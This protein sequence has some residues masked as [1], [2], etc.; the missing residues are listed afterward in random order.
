MRNKALLK[1]IA[2]IVGG[3][4][5]FPS[6]ADICSYSSFPDYSGLENAD[7]APFAVVRPRHSGH[8]REIVRF[9]G[10]ENIPLAICGG[11]SSPHRKN[12]RGNT[13][14]LLTTGLDRV[15]DIDR[16]NRL[17]VVEAGVT[18][19]RL[20]QQARE[21]S[22]FY[23]LA[24]SSGAIATIGGV[25][26]ANAAA[27]GELKYGSTINYVR[28][29][30][31]M[32]AK[33]EIMDCPAQ[34]DAPGKLAAGFPLGAIMCGSMGTLGVILEASI[35]LLPAPAATRN[36]IA[37]FDDNGHAALAAG[38]ITRTGLAPSRMEF[39]DKVCSALVEPV[40]DRP[41]LFLEFAGNACQVEEDSEACSEI[42]RKFGA[43]FLANDKNMHF[44]R[45]KNT[46]LAPALKGE[47][48]PF[49]FQRACCPVSR[50]RSLFEGIGEI[51]KQSGAPIALFA[52]AGIARAYVA[53]FINKSPDA[54]REAAKNLFTL[55]LV[56]NK[57][58][59]SD[60]DAILTREEWQK[61]HADM[62][63]YANAMRRIFDPGG[64]FSP[65]PLP[66]EEKLAGYGGESVP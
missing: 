19:E 30:R 3:E 20:N 42:L 21:K 58:L 55:E 27:S 60:S 59:E 37:G 45:W 22:L 53:I 13:L 34:N 8:M 41:S 14:L 52:H 15:K 50:L 47:Y 61:K 6:P 54:A 4:N 29:M 62:A 63:G 12:M 5:L 49:L 26:A 28:S 32:T 43:K 24:P 40:W 17:A 39:L 18:I 56:L 7:G 23:P 38:E 16:E 48:G 46:R 25:L 9:C 33:G 35:K 1:N 57:A 51:G 10:E 2:D 44:S 36:L 31:V 65:Q 11:G 66:G 64:L